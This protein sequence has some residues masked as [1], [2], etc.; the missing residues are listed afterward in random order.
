MKSMKTINSVPALLFI[1]AFLLSAC[2]I[3]DGSDSL[4]ENTLTIQSDEEAERPATTE[5]EAFSKNSPLPTQAGHMQENVHSTPNPTSTY[6]FHDAAIKSSVERYLNKSANEMTTEDWDYLSRVQAFSFD[7][8]NMNVTSLRD[9]PEHFPNLR[10]I[11]LAFSWFNAAQ[12]SMDDCKILEEMPF[13]RAVDIYSNGLPSLDFAQKLSY[14]ALRYTEEA[15]LS[16]DNNLVMVSVL[17]KDFI[18]S[19]V[20]G[21]IKEFVKVADGERVYELIVTDSEVQLFL[22]ERRNSDYF[23]LKSYPIQDRLPNISGGLIITDV[24]FDGYKDILVAQGYFGAQGLVKY[25]CYLCSDDTY[26]LNE[27]FSEI[28]NP[29]LD[30]TNSKVLGTWRNSAASHSWSMYSYINGAFTEIERL[31]QEPKILK[32][33]KED[34]LEVDIE[35]WIHTIEHF[36]DGNTESEVYPASDYTDDEWFEMFYGEDSFWGLLSDKWR[37]LNSHGTIMDWSIYG[38]G[39]DAQIIETISN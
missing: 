31:T 3:G 20:N 22:S 36:I 24:N 26:I 6:T 29:S 17:G 10:Y 34:G 5:D 33:T 39:P 30:I 11:S 23:F 38:S 32:T 8:F 16:E 27:S 37:T 28:S 19:N 1:C 2:G 21:H 25:T 13:L 15:Y 14:A 7:P 35:I 12:L 4:P 18:E 9:I